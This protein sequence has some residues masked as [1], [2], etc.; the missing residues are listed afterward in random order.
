MTSDED[1]RQGV[2][3]MLRG[4]TRPR[5]SVLESRRVRHGKFTNHHG[6]ACGFVVSVYTRLASGV[7]CGRYALEYHRPEANLT[8]AAYHSSPASATSS[9]RGWLPQSNETKLIKVTMS[10]S[11]PEV[12]ASSAA[13]RRPDSLDRL[14]C[15]VTRTRQSTALPVQIARRTRTQGR[16]AR[17][18]RTSFISCRFFGGP[19]RRLTFDD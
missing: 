14:L 16:S 1:S 10:R 4:S 15:N 18:G 7:A 3:R 5:T 17:W 6:G 12:A 13:C 19:N 9:F 2:C 8:T 11:W